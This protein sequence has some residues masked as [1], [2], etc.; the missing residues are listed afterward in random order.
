MALLHCCHRG[1]RLTRMQHEGHMQTTETKGLEEKLD[2]ET[3]GSAEFSGVKEEGRHRSTIDRFL[4]WP[5]AHEGHPLT[6]G[7]TPP[8]Q[9]YIDNQDKKLHCQILL[10]GV[11]AKDV[12]IQVLGNMLMISGEHSDSRNTDGKDFLR[13]EFTYGSFQRSLVPPCA[14]GHEA[15]VRSGELPA[16]TNSKE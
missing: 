1:S 7:F 5:S 10:P 14:H 2:D 15:A 3:S 11:D 13:R 16:R 6:A 8:V 12:N 4:S 9:S